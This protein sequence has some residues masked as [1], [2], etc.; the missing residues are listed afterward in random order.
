MWSAFMNGTGTG[1]G[2]YV[3]A[4]GWDFVPCSRMRRTERGRGRSLSPSRR[5]SSPPTFTHIYQSQ[6]G[7]Q[8]AAGTPIQEVLRGQMWPSPEPQSQQQ[9]QQ[10][11]RLKKKLEDLKKRHVQDKEEWMREKESLL[12][13]V[14]DIQGGENRRILLDLKTVLEEVQAEVKREE[15][16]R[17]ELQ[18]LYTR[19]RCSWELEKAELKCRIAQ[20][21]TREGAGLIGGGVQSAAGP[22]SV[23]SRG[24][25]E[26]RGE[27]ST[28][29]REREEQRRLLADTH[30]TAMDLRCRL[31]HNEKDWLRE[32]AELLERFDVER[33]E[34]ECQLKDMQRKIEELY[35][36]VRTKRGGTGL[37]GGQQDADDIL[38][39]LSIRSTSTGSSLLSD[40]ELLSSSSQSEP[41]RHPPSSG[42]G[43]K[44]NISG[45]DCVGRDDH[46]STCFQ[47][48]SLRQFDVGGRF[49][50]NDH[51][52]PDP[53]DELGSRGTW[54][55]DSV[56]DS[57]GAVD[58]IEL[59]AMFHGAP[60]KNGNESNAHVRPEESPLWA[61][62]S[63]GSVRKKN[64]TALNAA[65]KEIARVSE[66]L[67][68]Y[69][70]E[71]RKKSGDKR[72]RCESLCLP[73]EN[74]ML[75]GY[76]KTHLEVVEAPCDL[77]QIYDD[78]R[79]LEREN[80]ITLS[81]DNTWR[82]DRGPSKSWRT[83]TGDP[84]SYREA[85][86]SPGALSDGDTAGPP[87][88]PR[89][90]SWNLNSPTH[91]DT[92][93]YIP[94]SPTTTV[95]KCHS[96]CVLVDKKCSSPSIVRK[97]E[98]M[99]QENEGK[100]LIDGV[101]SSCSV[102]ANSECNMGCCHNRWSCDASKFTSSKLSTY[103]TVQK[104]FSEVNILTA[105]KDSRSDYCPGV[106]NL[107]LCELEMPPTVKELPLDLLLSSLETPPVGP[108]LQGSRRNIMLEQKTAEFN[109]T[110]FQAEMGRGA[111]ERNGVPVTDGCSA[112]RQPVSSTC[113]S[114]DQRPLRETL[115]TH[116][117]D[118][119]TSVTG[120]H[121]EVTLPLSTP[122]STVQNPKVQPRQM[123]CGPEGH[124]VR[125]EPEILSDFSSE[126]PQ[127]G[128]REAATISSP[129]PPTHHSEVKHK[130][131]T[132][133]R[134][135]QRRAATEPLF[136][137][138]GQSVDGSSSKNENP[139]RAKPQSAR[140]A[141]SLQQ[142]S[143]E[144]KQR[145]MTQPGHQA[146][147]KHA[148]VL[149]SQSDSSRPGP[150]MMNEH[151]WKA[152][153]LAAYPRPEGSRSNYGA[154]ERILKNYESAARA[155]QNQNRPNET[156]SSPN[157][158]VEQEETV[159]QLDMLDMDPLPL[160]PTLRHTQTSHT[161]Q[162]HSTHAQLSSHGT[163]GLKEVHLTVQA[164][165]DFRWN[166]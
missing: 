87:V 43:R 122:N 159:T 118:V 30:S 4:P 36:D 141:V 46:H 134:K 135:T 70:D 15:E 19:D 23:A 59:D 94:E 90:S 81:P 113:A 107:K 92:E 24:A 66:E 138:P 18:L 129:P 12:R 165:D 164:Q 95:R 109:R 34:W 9:Q 38:H 151:P 51:S 139:H 57:E 80:W 61:E 64:T 105:G 117:T 144:N 128:L 155:Q 116:C 98:A 158:G 106:G 145:A 29:R 142:P 89:S 85:Q 56:T 99:L 31:E 104:S 126:Q 112:G 97:F 78:L 124:E 108:N 123:R 6:S 60:Q 71:I 73:E 14:A 84:D 119:T 63:Y 162:T 101:V 91:P 154:V 157:V 40:N 41:I 62:L 125:M 137:E 50:Q 69:Q 52:Q 110:L 35:C 3:P 47:A 68:S 102:P 74:Q 16:K 147:L 163:T 65:L 13:E 96:P 166:T 131:H 26:Q 140:V 82:A 121:P 76:D 161:S 133:S 42:F 132:A 152:L 72:N 37:D 11:T 79:A 48:D 83:N 115:Q 45:S 103:G 28:L 127:I 149:P 17:S 136:T 67:C 25:R 86:T 33:R 27:T 77:S 22:G 130:V 53:V 75:F 44:R 148:S 120:V 55:Q 20:L 146:Q 8:A 58:T 111:E 54:Q 1:G 10:H 153:T 21:E 7:G 88:P 2:G 49:S 160:P 93:L 39:R 156:A 143:A 32:K 5:I 150:R 114:D 100:V